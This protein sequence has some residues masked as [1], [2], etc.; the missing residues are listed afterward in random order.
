MDGNQAVS[1]VGSSLALLIVDDS[2]VMR[3]FIKRV[4][5]L[6]GLP[7]TTVHEACDGA[8]A[9]ETLGR[10]VID[11]VLSDINMP[12]MNGEE[13]IRRMSADEQ[14]R[15][16]PVIIV[17]TDSTHYRMETMRERG[18]RGYL[19]KPFH[20]EQL[21]GEVERVLAEAS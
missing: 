6:S 15:R 20:P 21:R 17:S 13:L 8:A 3:G 18:V 19:Q 4:L 7:V 5:R 1:P 14:F 10:E 16:I 2:P 11:I 9:L 12:V